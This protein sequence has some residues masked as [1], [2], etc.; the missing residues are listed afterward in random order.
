VTKTT[1]KH[2]TLVYRAAVT[3]GG[4]KGKILLELPASEPGAAGECAEAY[5]RWAIKARGRCA[6]R[7]PAPP[8][9]PTAP[10]LSPPDSSWWPGDGRRR[11][12][13]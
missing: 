5:D 12:G 3:S 13:A 4:E 10:A 1:N 9:W 7:P 8:A 2:G 11:D 6:A